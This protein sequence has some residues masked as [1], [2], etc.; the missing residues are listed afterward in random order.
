MSDNGE[1]PTD[2]DQQGESAATAADET[3]R[4]RK[5][6]RFATVFFSV[7]LALL[8]V[9]G[10]VFAYYLTRVSRAIDHVDRNP[11]LMPSDTSSDGTPRPAEPTS[12]TAA[13]QP[14]TFVL[15]GSD[16]RGSDQGRSD[17]L[18]V[19]YLSG[20]RKDIY[21]VSFP[22]D[23]WVT[24][25]GRGEAK[26]NAAYAWGGPPLTIA[27]LES[28][29]STRMQH[30]AVIDFEGFIQLT[31]VLGGVTVYNQQASAS[32][33]YTFPEGEITIRG[34]QALAYVRERY[35]L[36]NGDL[37]RAGRQRDV[38]E[39]IMKKT[40]TPETIA[41]P[42]KFGKTVDA[43]A[44]CMTVSSELDSKTIRSVATS[45]RINPETGIHSLQAP[46][47]GFGTS[48]DGQSIDLVDKA[49]LAEL[50]KAMQT[51]TMADYAKKYGR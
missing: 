29:L 14:M 16:S 33:G 32:D 39:A 47:D 9:G 26:I 12:T 6:R 4:R 3:Q 34:K 45:L 1:Y 28:M 48:S 41:N 10:G 43:F 46:L 25:P 21:L 11:S 31:E 8:L 37:D 30:A 51:D 42:V 15:M 5:G 44:A 7:F 2:P 27:T 19:A 22:R 35:D 17:S 18:M 13:G 38:V 40:L 36:A 49:G 24:I 50:A 20:D 23:M